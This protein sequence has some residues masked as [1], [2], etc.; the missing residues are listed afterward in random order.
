MNALPSFKYLQS[1][2]IKRDEN[3]QR[4]FSA[5]YDT[6]ITVE[7]EQ[8]FIASSP[9]G[10]KIYGFDNHIV[11]KGSVNRRW[12]KCIEL[13]VEQ[14]KAIIKRANGQYRREFLSEAVEVVRFNLA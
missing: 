13:T 11:V 8:T 10:N 6:T 14:V 5:H 4:A 3:G 9:R 1:I 7:K 12:Q 2:T